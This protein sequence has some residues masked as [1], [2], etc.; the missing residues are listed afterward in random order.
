MLSFLSPLFLIGAI[1]AA[2]PIVL[3]LLRRE[4]EPRIRFAPVKLLKQAPVEYTE[5]RHIRELLLLALRVTALVLLAV[6]F[7]RPFLASGAAVGSAGVTI[8]ALD[9]SYSMSAPGVFDR[10]KHLA[11]AAINRAPAG[12]LVGVVTFSDVPNLAATPGPDR[13]L[14][15]SAIDGA[16]PGFGATRYRGAL[17]AAVQAFGGRRGTIVVVT[18][19]QESGWDAG[20]RA[21]VPESARIEIADTGP[22][23]P[24]LAVT[25]IRADSDRIVAS[26]R[27]S[28]DTSQTTRA[29]LTIDNKPAA[30]NPVTVGPRA[31]VDVDFPRAAIRRGPHARG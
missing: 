1:T 31:S 28:S 9:T 5:R 7:A 4:P 22:A 24:N 20:D 13:A 8:I 25:A 19:L 10:A 2:V 29:R 6:A 17:G 26:V 14:A 21:S 30:D 12:D 27:N 3:H 18:D 11:T 23:P 16:T 15:R